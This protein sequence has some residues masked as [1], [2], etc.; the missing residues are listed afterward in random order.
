M[1]SAAL[2]SFILNMFS[3]IQQQITVFGGLNIIVIGDLA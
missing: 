3:I 2:F 1:V